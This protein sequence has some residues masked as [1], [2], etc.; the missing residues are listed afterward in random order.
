MKLE[1][2]CSRVDTWLLATVAQ[3]AVSA[4]LET[5]DR[6]TSLGSDSIQYIYPELSSLMHVSLYLLGADCPSDAEASKS[7]QAVRLGVRCTVKQHHP[8]T[9][10]L[11]LL[12]LG[13][14]SA[15][16]VKL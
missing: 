10:A 8:S 1:P 11:R 13:P 4:F 14:T 9:L 6:V 12:A 16:E 3:K 7:N 5:I 2:V 15:Y